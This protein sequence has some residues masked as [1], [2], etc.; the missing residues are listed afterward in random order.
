MTNIT[1]D[2]S[3]LVVSP[4]LKKNVMMTDAFS[5]TDLKGDECNATIIQAGKI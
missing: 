3:A 2:N 5:A 4:L 1:K